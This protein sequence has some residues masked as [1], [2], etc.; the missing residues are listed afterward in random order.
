MSRGA[1]Y[2]RLDWFPIIVRRMS[3]SGGNVMWAQ[4]DIAIGSIFATE[5]EDGTNDGI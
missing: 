5:I 3:N 2:M 4:Q 1:A